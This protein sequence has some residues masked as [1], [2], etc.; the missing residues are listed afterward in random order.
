MNFNP[1]WPPG[2]EP[3]RNER[4]HMPPAK[5]SIQTEPI[6]PL[7]AK[8]RMTLASVSNKHTVKPWSA[9]LYGPAGIGKSTFGAATPAPIFITP[10]EGL[11]EIVDAN[12]NIPP[13]FP[14][15]QTFDEVL[16]CVD[17]LQESKH[18]YR[19]LVL[20]TV[21]W[22][23]PIIWSHMFRARKTDS[24]KV[25][26]SIEDYGYGKGYSYALDEWRRLVARFERL[27]NSHGMNVLLLGHSQV[28][29]FNNPEG[30]NFDRYTLKVHQKAGDFLREWTK[31]VLFVNYDIL[32]HKSAGEMKAKGVGSGARVMHTEQRPAFDAKNRYSLP[33]DMQF[34]YAEFAQ[35]TTGAAPT[36]GDEFQTLAIELTELTKGTSLE[37]MAQ[38]AITQ[39]AG[40]VPQLKQLINRA[41]IK[42][43]QEQEHVVE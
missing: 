19:T 27:M 21:D 41:A 22:L 2:M 4:R 42:L 7:P 17:E 1:L 29:A 18:E 13:H 37:A 23:E 28:K 3:P 34:D 15:P 16:D 35:Y 43:Q 25:A 32:S 38:Q 30:V 39:C 14:Q 5:A 11:S 6:N 24:G 12:G 20:D 33:A 8:R 9:L 31:A 10:E 40:H 26:T 36:G